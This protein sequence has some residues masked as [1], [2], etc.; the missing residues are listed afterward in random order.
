VLSSLKPPTSDPLHLS[1]IA[2]AALPIGAAAALSIYPASG[3]PTL[4]PFALVTGTACPGCGLTRAAAA[5]VR[6]DTAAAL[7]L[8]PLIVIVVV[9]LIGVWVAGFYRRSG[10]RLPV[11]PRIINGLLLLTGVLFVVTWAIRLA[12]GSL[13]A[14]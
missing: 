11:H 8:H 10:R 5:L 7:S 1:R 6:G 14:V 12:N 9:W 13:P 3:G 2:W 4:C